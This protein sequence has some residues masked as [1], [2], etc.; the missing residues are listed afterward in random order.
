M[1]NNQFYT[2]IIFTHPSSFNERFIPGSGSP[3]I[4]ILGKKVRKKM[5]L[6]KMLAK[7]KLFPAKSEK[8]ERGKKKPLI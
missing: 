7:V 3:Y 8:R 4:Q 5:V 6:F 1:K 2:Y